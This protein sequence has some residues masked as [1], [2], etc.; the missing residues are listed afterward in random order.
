MGKFINMVVI[1]LYVVEVILF[2]M[3]VYAN[4]CG[5]ILFSV[6]HMIMLI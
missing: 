4:H 1:S 3:C 2:Q 6:M 5:T